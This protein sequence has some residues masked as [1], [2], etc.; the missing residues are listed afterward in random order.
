MLDVQQLHSF[1]TEKVENV[2]GE[3]YPH[4]C[5]DMFMISKVTGKITSKKEVK[6]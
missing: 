4:L 6:F 3:K 5:S 1:R 2:E